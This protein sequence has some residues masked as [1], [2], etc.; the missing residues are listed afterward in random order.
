MRLR[1]LAHALGLTDLGGLD[2]SEIE[3]HGEP[4]VDV[5]HAT[6]LTDSRGMVNLVANVMVTTT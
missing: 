6:S 5:I 1:W 3:G 2:L 4:V